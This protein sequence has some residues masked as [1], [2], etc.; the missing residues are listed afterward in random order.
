MTDASSSQGKWE[1]LWGDLKDVFNKAGYF[2]WLLI[3]VLFGPSTLLT[4]LRKQYDPMEA[5][6]PVNPLIQVFF[7]AWPVVISATILII[8][9]WRKAFDDMEGMERIYTIGACIVVPYLIAYY[10]GALGHTET[11]RLSTTTSW[12]QLLHPGHLI[13]MVF[14]IIL[15]YIAPPRLELTVAAVLS[16][17][18]FTWVFEKLVARVRRWREND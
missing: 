8:L 5:L 17:V 18:F 6:E 12:I 3:L 9:L 14:N 7:G 1:A 16:G 4:T 10:F 15:F 2:S 13:G 11:Q